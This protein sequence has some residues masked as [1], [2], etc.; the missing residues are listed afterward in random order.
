MCKHCELTIKINM[1]S[2]IPNQVTGGDGS[3]V[4]VIN[5]GGGGR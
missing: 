3:I 4:I 5:T 2:T 1:L